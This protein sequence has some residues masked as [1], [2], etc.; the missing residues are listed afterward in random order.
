ML[1]GIVNNFKCSSFF[2]LLH[3]HVRRFYFSCFPLPVHLWRCFWKHVY[4]S[5]SYSAIIWLQCTITLSSNNCLIVIAVSALHILY[6]HAL[7]QHSLHFKLVFI[8]SKGAID[9]PLL[10]AHFYF[11]IKGVFLF[12]R[13]IIKWPTQ[14]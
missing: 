10:T 12:Q 11:P 13:R 2:S 5:L 8:C 1:R 14:K 6:L 9:F 3:L 4:K 7:G